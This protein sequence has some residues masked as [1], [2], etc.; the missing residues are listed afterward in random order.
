[1]EGWERRG[2]GGETNVSYVTALL[3]EW[4]HDLWGHLDWIGLGCGRVTR[5][6]DEETGR[7]HVVYIFFPFFVCLF[8]LC[9]FLDV[10]MHIGD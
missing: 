3:H 10:G 4:V 7:T 8:F 9:S 1:M 6:G 5:V 2:G